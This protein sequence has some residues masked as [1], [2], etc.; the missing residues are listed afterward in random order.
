MRKR[1]KVTLKYYKKKWKLWD[2]LNMKFQTFAKTIISL[3]IIAL[4]GKENGIW[5]LV[6]QHTLLMASID[7]G[8]SRVILNIFQM[9]IVM[10][11]IMN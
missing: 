10:L 8:I 6:L 4:I 5:G 7:N 9:L 1:Q 11:S 3:S 2:I